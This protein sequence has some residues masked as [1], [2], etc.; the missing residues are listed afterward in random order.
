MQQAE[1]ASAETARL[2]D[3]VT[4]R[5]AAVAEAEARFITLQAE[6]KHTQHKHTYILHTHSERVVCFVVLGTCVSR[7]IDCRCFFCVS[8]GGKYASSSCDWVGAFKRS[9]VASLPLRRAR[10]SAIDVRKI[11][12]FVL[13][14]SCAVVFSFLLGDICSFS[15]C[16][17]PLME[18]FD[19]LDEHI[20]IATRGAACSCVATQSDRT[21]T[22]SGANVAGPA[23]REGSN[24]M[25]TVCAIIVP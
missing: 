4:K 24:S 17:R 2:V 5:E 21:R 6:V 19:W 3:S 11:L 8:L 23:T 12:R 9:K 13:N 14:F 22:Q 7:L 20:A 10:V 18:C 1:D 15:Y 16:I 25:C